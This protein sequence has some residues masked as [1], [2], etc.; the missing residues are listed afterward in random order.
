LEALMAGEKVPKKYPGKKHIKL[1]IHPTGMVRSLMQISVFPGLINS[2]PGAPRISLDCGQCG[3]P[4]IVG[5]YTS[6]FQEMAFKCGNCGAVL[7]S[8]E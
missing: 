1:P 3:K 7:Q 8:T 5:F 4:L 2:V 6:Q